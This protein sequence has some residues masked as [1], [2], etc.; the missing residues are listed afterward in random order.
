MEWNISLIA[1]IAC[2]IKDGEVT[3]ALSLLDELDQHLARM[4]W[5]LADIRADGVAE[6]TLHEQKLYMMIEALKY[7]ESESDD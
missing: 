2:L 7:L 4:W 5:A 6:L 1:K 3:D